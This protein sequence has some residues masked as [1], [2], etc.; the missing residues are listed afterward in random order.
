MIRPYL[1]DMIN[2]HKTR[3]EWKIQLTMRI[4]FISL[5][6]SKETRTMYTKSR[7]IEIMMG[8]ETD[9]IIKEFHKSLLQNYKKDLKE[10]MRGSEFVHDSIDLLYYHLQKIGLKRGRS[11]ID[12]PKWLKNK[13]AIINL[14][15]VMII[16]FRML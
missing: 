13:K 1:R 3:R 8:N 12:S 10:P 15:I 14:E 11:Y 4:N 16:V 2:D 9:D 6:D 5:K 7:N